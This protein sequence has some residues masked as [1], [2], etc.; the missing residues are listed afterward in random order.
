[1]PDVPTTELTEPL[2][3]KIYIIYCMSNSVFVCVCEAKMLNQKSAPA[4]ERSER[5][6][7]D[8][9]QKGPDGK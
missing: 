5:A 1:M 4:W 2:G 3:Y 7:A 6:I 9:Y 8:M